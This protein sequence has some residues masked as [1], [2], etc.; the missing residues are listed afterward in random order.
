MVPRDDECIIAQCTPQGK[1]ALALLRIS[2]STA[3]SVVD[4]MALLASSKKII[5]VPTHT[6]HFGTILD[7]LGQ[8]IDQVMI[9]VMDGPRTFTGQN[10]VEI[11]CHNNSF[12][13]EAIIQQ[14]LKRGA[15]IA[16][17]GEFTRRAYEAGKIDL[18]QAESINELITAQTQHALKRS[19]AQLEGSFSHWI[20]A[21]EKDL[22]QAIAWCEASFE[23]LDEEIEFGAQLQERLS[24]LLT[25]ISN[26]KRTFN[27]QQQIREGIKVAFIG[28]V[29]V[30]KSSL[31]NTLLNQKRAIVTD[32]PGTTRDSIEAS[33]LYE[34]NS[35]TLIDTAG[36]RETNNTIEQEGIKRSHE[37]AHKADIILL[38]YDGSKKMS[39]QELTIYMNIKNKYP[40]KCIVV[41]SKSDC[42]LASV[43]ALSCSEEMVVSAHSRENI[44]MLEQEI[45]KK[46]NDLFQELDSPFLVNKR[47]YHLLEHCESKLTHCA[48]LLK[49]APAYE[50]ISYI[51]QDTVTILSE[52]TGRSIAEAAL[53][54]VFKEFCVG[55]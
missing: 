21:L 31:F 27:V 2:G 20:A 5:N 6:I 44:E 14:A 36:L 45:N 19:L 33:I 55:K 1:G 17:E 38:I 35:I 53:D 15:R 37:E 3:R 26:L 39:E 4:S 25:K 11:T 29:N 42:P 50:I 34:G 22:L 32:K 46:I 47:Q 43:N 48:R 9:I 7:N 8:A 54:T 12:L 49:E 41:R 18:I 10:T 51:L 52:L 40:K 30:G 28:S 23:F 13:I 24:Q 16:Q